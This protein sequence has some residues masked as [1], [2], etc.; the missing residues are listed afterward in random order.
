[1]VGSPSQ[2]HPIL[3]LYLIISQTLSVSHFLQHLATMHPH[4][5]VHI[6]WI[7]STLPRQPEGL[8]LFQFSVENIRV[9]PCGTELV[10]DRQSLVFPVSR[11]ELD[12]ESALEERVAFMTYHFFPPGS[13]TVQINQ[14][15]R[16][17]VFFHSESRHGPFLKIDVY[18]YKEGQAEV[19]EEDI[20]LSEDD[21]D[22]EL[23]WEDY[24]EEDME[25]FPIA[26]GEVEMQQALANSMEGGGLGGAG[27]LG[28]LPASKAA[29]ETLQTLK[30]EGVQGKVKEKGCS[31]CFDDFVVGMEVKSMPCS[32]VFHGGCIGRWLEISHVCPLC[33]F[34]MPTGDDDGM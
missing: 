28:G 3:R 13:L 4:T 9:L 10:E 33:R 18:T 11:H 15:V 23:I 2:I 12:N 16:E 7:H 21:D 19:G 14:M 27:G 22:E 5:N 8:L 26:E 34:E 29:I 20:D 32:H 31:I 30:Y 17:F 24:V 1:M 25:E 6:Q